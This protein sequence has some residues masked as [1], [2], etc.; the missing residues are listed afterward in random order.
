M[1][2]QQLSF[3]E[4]FMLSGVAAGVSKT[5]AAPIERVKLLVQNQAE[6]IKQ[7]TLDRPYN[8]EW[9]QLTS[10][11][12]FPNFRRKIIFSKMTSNDF[13]I[14]ESS[15]APSEL[16]LLRES[17]PSGE[18][19]WLTSS[20]IS[21][22][23]PSTLPS[24]TPLKPCSRSHPMPLLPW[25]SPQT[26]PLVDSPDHCLFPWSTLSTSLELDWPTIANVSFLNSQKINYFK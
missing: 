14:K 24:K 19:T 26:L 20:D 25:S 18:E 10:K 2:K 12:N 23:R 16:S 21:L 8:G 22:P 15:T 6:M 13:F 4:N 5:G 1:G 11:F 9:P 17:A 3:V 7:G